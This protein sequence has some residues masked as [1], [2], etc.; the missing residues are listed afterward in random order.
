M[1]ELCMQKVTNLCVGQIR[2]CWKFYDFFPIF[3]IGSHQ[4]WAIV[5]GK[6]IGLL[7]SLQNEFLKD[8][9]IWAKVLKSLQNEC[10]EGLLK[11]NI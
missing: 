2:T 8:V 6:F 9:L 7:K 4:F 5:V 1:N 3:A 10:Q 11:W